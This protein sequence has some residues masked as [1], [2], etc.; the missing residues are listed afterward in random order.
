MSSGLLRD[1][2][3]SPPLVLPRAASALDA[4][5]ATEARPNVRAALARHPDCPHR[6][7]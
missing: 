6:L 4:A 5:P 3:T 7:A 1:V 2:M